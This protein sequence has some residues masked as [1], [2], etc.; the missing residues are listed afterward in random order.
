[1]E[2]EIRLTKDEE[3][4]Q[5]KNLPIRKVGIG[6]EFCAHRFPNKTELFGIIRKCTDRNIGW[7]IVTPFM[8]NVAINMFF[9]IID[10]IAKKYKE[11]DIVVNDYGFIQGLATR[12]QGVRFKVIIGHMLAQSYE[13]CP[14]HEKGLAAENAFIHDNY[15]LNN[16]HNNHVINFFKSRY[17]MKGIELNCLPHAIQSAP[18]Y[19]GQ[20]LEV[21]FADRYYPASISRNCHSARFHKMPASGECR[22]TCDSFHKI[23]NRKIC[24]IDSECMK[25]DDPAAGVEIPAFFVAGN[26][27]FKDY[28]DNYSLPESDQV[29]VYIDY[30]FYQDAA[31]IAHRVAELQ[32]GAGYEDQS[33][34]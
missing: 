23:E 6:D 33:A 5:I 32:R 24:V 21:S 26:A 10:E 9:D 28:E 7:S 1:M 20:G 15:L 12:Y 13:E 19:I 22:T 8:S 27:I 4:G 25:Y 11:I 31:G 14:W 17:N 2:I 34:G 29:K 3:F 30:R 18:Y 16:F